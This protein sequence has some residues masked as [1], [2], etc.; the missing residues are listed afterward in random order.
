M[1]PPDLSVVFESWAER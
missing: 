1:Y